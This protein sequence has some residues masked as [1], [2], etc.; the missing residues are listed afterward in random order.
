M[1]IVFALYVMFRYG[2]EAPCCEN[3]KIF[4]LSFYTC[5]HTTVGLVCYAVFLVMLENAQLKNAK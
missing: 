5:M 4:L 1:A 2:G 3:V